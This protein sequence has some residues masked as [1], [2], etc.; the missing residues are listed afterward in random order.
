MRQ[1]KSPAVCQD[2]A[3]RVED[4]LTAE[5]ARCDV[6]QRLRPGRGDARVE[7]LTGVPEHLVPTLVE[8]LDGERLAGTLMVARHLGELGAL[9]QGWDV[10]RARDVIWTLN[11]VQVYDL[12][13]RRRKWSRPAYVEWVGTAMA[14]ALLRRREQR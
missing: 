11:S 8:V 6:R 14:D 4:V 5:V 1:Q 9:G 2:A 7:S 12:L 10:E 13:V 3:E